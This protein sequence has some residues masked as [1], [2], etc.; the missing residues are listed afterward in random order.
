MSTGQCTGWAGSA[1]T[2]DQE[3]ERTGLLG[4]R[5]RT[6]SR[7]SARAQHLSAVRPATSCAP[8]NGCQVPGCIRLPVSRGRPPCVLCPASLYSLSQGFYAPHT[9]APTPLRAPARQPL[10]EGQPPP[11]NL[12]LGLPVLGGPQHVFVGVH[13]R[14]VDGGEPVGPGVT[15]ERGCTAMCEASCRH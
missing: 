10:Q 6:R 15:A 12:L 8:L 4:S 11:P 13:Q 14:K 1:A 2:G 5:V 3:G 7:A 9:P